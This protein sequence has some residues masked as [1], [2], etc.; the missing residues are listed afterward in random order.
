MTLAESCPICGSA[1]LATMTYD[2]M[3]RARDGAQL[4]YHAHHSKCNHCGEEFF[5]KRQSRASNRVAATA[6]R[7]HAGLLGPADIIGIRAKYRVTQAELERIL[8]AG[9]KTAVRWESGAVCQSQAIDQLLR[10]VRD[11]P[12]R[13]YELAEAA[14]VTVRPV[15]APTYVVH[16]VASVRVTQGTHKKPWA[17]RRPR[18]SKVY[19][20]LAGASTV[21]V[22]GSPVACF[23][24][25]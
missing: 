20:T 10:E 13:F 17:K 16:C 25:A 11:S 14:G 1:D 21:T 15:V 2:G 23:G 24:G 22:T 3:I 5:T 19:R 6:L 7:V 4:P 8:R 18:Q 9:K 12:N